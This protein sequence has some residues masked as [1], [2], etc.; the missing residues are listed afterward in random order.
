[1]P[2]IDPLFIEGLQLIRETVLIGMC[3]IERCKPD[4]ENGLRMIQNNFRG[5]ANGALQRRFRTYRNRLIEKKKVS[6]HHRRNKSILPYV[7]R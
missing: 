2:G 6:D 4:T 7:M 3:E 1:M 5:L